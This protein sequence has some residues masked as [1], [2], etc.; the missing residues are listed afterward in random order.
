M[1]PC[2]KSF[3]SPLKSCIAL[4][5]NPEIYFHLRRNIFAIYNNMLCYQ[6]LGENGLILERLSVPFFEHIEA[7]FYFFL[8]FPYLSQHSERRIHLFFRAQV[9]FS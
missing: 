4:W 7:V 6:L 8:F 9:H 3:A 1:I 5:A 2:M